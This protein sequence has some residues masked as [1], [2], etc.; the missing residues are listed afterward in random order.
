M[1]ND[2][3]A[4]GLEGKDEEGISAFYKLMLAGFIIFSL[5]SATI[6]QHYLCYNVP[7][8]PRVPHYAT[9]GTI[10]AAPMP[11]SIPNMGRVQWKIICF[12]LLFFLSSRCAFLRYSA[13]NSGSFF[14]VFSHQY[15]L[16]HALFL[17]TK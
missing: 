13:S 12:W 4:S 16:K 14:L 11:A 2:I 6:V 5:P 9:E 15:I 3:D 17:A 10:Q 7:V 1:R 8:L